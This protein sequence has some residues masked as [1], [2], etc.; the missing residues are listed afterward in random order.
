MIET[1]LA[2]KKTGQMPYY[3]KFPPRVEWDWMLF[4]GIIP[5]ALAASLLSDTFAWSRTPP[6]WG[7]AFGGAWAPRLAAAFA[8]GIMMG[9]ASRWAGGCTSGHGISGSMQLALSSWLS[10]FSFFTGGILT[11]LLIYRVIAV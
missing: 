8:G 7:A 10:V 1:L 4:L 5:G 3:Q 2:G 9:F 6:L 11:A